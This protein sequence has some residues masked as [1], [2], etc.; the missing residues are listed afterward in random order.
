MMMSSEN[1]R[2]HVSEEAVVSTTAPTATTDG[3]HNPVHVQSRWEDGVA[4]FALV[5]HPTQRQY[6]TT[7]DMDVFFG[8]IT[9]ALVQWDLKGMQC[10]AFIDIRTLQTSVQKRNYYKFAKREAEYRKRNKE[11]HERVVYKSVVLM[12][13]SKGFV[14]NIISLALRLFPF[15]E[16]TVHIESD[17]SRATEK[18]RTFAF[19]M[20]CVGST[21]VEAEKNK[22]TPPET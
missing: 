5:P 1:V 14:K 13:P 8:A 6:L 11:L 9:E 3:V 4:V 18:C 7:A 12:P 15:D 22:T 19:E 10:T 21:A 17:V 20:R 2:E 16:D